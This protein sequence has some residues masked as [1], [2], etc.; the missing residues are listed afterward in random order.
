M[1]E[2]Q[3]DVHVREQLVLLMERL[4]QKASREE[5]NSADFRV[6]Q[7]FSGLMERSMNSAREYVRDR[8]NESALKTENRLNDLERNIMDRITEEQSRGHGRRGGFHPSVAYGGGG[9]LIA[10]VILAALYLL[11]VIPGG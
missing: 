9:G 11:G 3:S 6:L 7:E 10:S 2:R 8:V 1:D 5:M 4:G